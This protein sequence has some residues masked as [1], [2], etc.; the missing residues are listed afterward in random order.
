MSF[1]PLLKGE[2]AS[3]GKP[4]FWHYPH[5]ANQ[6]GTPCT[7]IRDGDWKLIEWH[8]DGALELYNIAHDIGEKS[9]LSTEQ[10]DKVKELHAKLI[11]WRKDV[12]A[13]MP[14]PNPNFDP[15]AKPETN[16]PKKGIVGRCS[17]LLVVRARL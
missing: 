11:T 8:E 5:Y 10:P 4:L 7:T 6:G 9:N 17:L 2:Q 13:L 3:R 15:N 1:V 14:S 16:A 12:G